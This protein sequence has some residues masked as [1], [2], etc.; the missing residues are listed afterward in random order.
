MNDK[1]Y[2]YSKSRHVKAGKGVNEVVADT[3][4]YTDLDSIQ[5]WRQILSNFYV[6]PFVYEGKT[7]RSVEHAFQAKKINLV[8]PEAAYL[9]T[10]ESGHEIGLGNG[11]IAQKNRKLRKLN[12]EQIAIWNR[13]SEDI[14]ID[15]TIERVKQSETYRH[16]LLATKRAQL[17]HI[18]VRKSAIRNIYLE[19]I[20]KKL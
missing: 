8:D 4:I 16:V 17:W 7:Y 18:R 20:R 9:F 10:L 2:Y 5:N 11:D 12:K 6:E 3:T 1:L 14:M 15:I 19:E 13:M